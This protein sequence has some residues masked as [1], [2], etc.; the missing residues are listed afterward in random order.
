M[1]VLFFAGDVGQR[2]RLFRSFAKENTS[3]F[4]LLR[5]LHRTYL[6]HPAKAVCEVGSIRKIIAK[7]NRPTMLAYF[8]WQG[9]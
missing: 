1:L 3:C 9:M 8:S 4:L 7:K 2:L 5:S 6:W